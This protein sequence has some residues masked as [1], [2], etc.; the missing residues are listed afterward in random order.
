MPS[1]LQMDTIRSNLPADGCYSLVNK[2]RLLASGYHSLVTIEYLQI[3]ILCGCLY[4]CPTTKTDSFQ[5]TMDLV[6]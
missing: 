1:A 2:S 3:L 4:S 5:E 6:V